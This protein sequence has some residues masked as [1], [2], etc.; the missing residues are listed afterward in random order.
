MIRTVTP[1]YYFV[2][3]AYYNQQTFKC[4]DKLAKFTGISEKVFRL[5]RRFLLKTGYLAEAKNVKRGGRHAKIKA[6]AK[7]YE[8]TRKGRILYRVLRDVY[9]ITKEKK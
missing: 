4:Q 5:Y 9:E 6:N 3:D 7:Y 2:L 1:S 8:V